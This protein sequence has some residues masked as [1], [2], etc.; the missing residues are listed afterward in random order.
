MAT[1]T[2][3]STN[4]LHAYATASN[5][6]A[7]ASNGHAN[8]TREGMRIRTSSVESA[9]LRTSFNTNPAG[10]PYPPTTLHLPIH[11]ASNSS[12]YVTQPLKLSA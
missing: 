9:K 1:R 3:R 11:P 8:S 7:G 12:S 10:H 5:A 6:S 4:V 2:A